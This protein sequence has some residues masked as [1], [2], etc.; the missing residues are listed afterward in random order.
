[1]RSGYHDVNY[2]RVAA[3]KKFQSTCD[4]IFVVTDIKRGVDDPIIKEVIQEMSSATG[5]GKTT[6]PNITVICSHAGVSFKSAV[7]AI[8]CPR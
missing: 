3:A 2:A 7:M 4:E 6:R 8:N 5:V 1:M